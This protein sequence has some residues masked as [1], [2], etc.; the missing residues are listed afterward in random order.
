MCH[1]LQFPDFRQRL[2][3]PQ[4]GHKSV[5]KRREER[6]AG[7]QNQETDKEDHLPRAQGSVQDEERLCSLKHYAVRNR[8]NKNYRPN[9][10]WSDL[11]YT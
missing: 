4:T 1:G 11:M 3:G 8:R 7:G 5:Q 10:V 6:H 2:P 9:L